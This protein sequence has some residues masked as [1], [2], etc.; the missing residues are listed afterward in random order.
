MNALYGSGFGG[1]AAPTAIGNYS[2]VNY[3]NAPGSGRTGG[4]SSSS[5]QTSAG[6]LTPPGQD[7][8]GPSGEEIETVEPR[9]IRRDFP[10]TLLWEPSLITDPN[11]TAYMD[12][13]MA[14]SI[15]TWRMSTVASTM[16]GK[17]GGNT[18]GI[19]VFQDFFVDL[20]LPVA[21]TQNDEIS[22]PVAVYNYLEESQIV[23]I[24]LEVDQNAPWFELMDTS[25]KQVDLEAGEVTV[26][27]FRIRALEVGWHEL[28]V[29]GYGTRMSD[30]IARRIEVLP[31][32]MEFHVNVSD[33]L[34]GNETNHILHI[35]IEAIDGASR[36]LVK[37]YP[38]IFSQVVE[39]L[40]K[41]FKV[42]FG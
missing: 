1:F 9:K 19:V 22:M 8:E 3:Q 31:D 21:L 36:I 6:F 35:P 4:T 15:T 33:R 41:L 13:N 29:F 14:D 16:D 39:G 24:K 18:E 27:Y 37:I 2:S 34:E 7:G 12:A 5:T 17:L 11:G 40:E 20:D 23:N 10:E 32:G 26:V 28:T 42:P 38:G 30:A 25:E